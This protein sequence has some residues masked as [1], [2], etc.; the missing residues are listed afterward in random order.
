MLTGN[1]PPVISGDTVLYVSQS[2]QSIYTLSVSDP[3]DTFT[4]TLQGNPPPQSDYSFDRTDNI[5]TFTWT[6]RTT[7][8]VQL[9]FVANDSQGA[10]SVLHPLVRLCACAMN[11]ECVNSTG[12]GGMDRFLLQDCVCGT[13]K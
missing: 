1:N 3:N 7:D 6:P 4:V 2:K 12:D 10:A 8:S 5:I 13:G 9:M 11:A